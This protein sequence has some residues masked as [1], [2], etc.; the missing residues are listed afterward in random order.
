MLAYLLAVFHGGTLFGG[1]SSGVQM[2]YGAVP[3]D[4]THSGAR[5]ITVFTS[6]FLHATLL[7]LLASMLFLAIF[8]PT[9]EDRLGPVRFLLLYLLGGLLLL[10]VRVLVDPNTTVPVLG[11]AGAI[12]AVLIGYIALYPRAR[13]I[14]L[15]LM[16]FFF[17]IVEIPA[18]LLLALWFAL[19]ICFGLTGPT[20]A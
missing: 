12:T 6:L 9:L 10:G 15:V 16:L 3:S 1:P 8:G 7:Q 18:V 13:V 4:L 19:Q 11:A 17:T 20:Y 5:W 14:S 2:R